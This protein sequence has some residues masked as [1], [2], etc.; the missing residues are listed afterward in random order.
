MMLIRI[1]LLGRESNAAQPGLALEITL[2]WRDTYG[3]RYFE[4]WH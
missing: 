3:K 2:D 1:P 4:L